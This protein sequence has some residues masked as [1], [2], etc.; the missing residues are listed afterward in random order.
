MDDTL[1]LKLTK[2]TAR[3]FPPKT[4]FISLF[5]ALDTVSEYDDFY[6]DKNHCIYIKGESGNY[7]MIYEGSNGEWA[8]VL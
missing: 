6:F 3:K 7:R 8:T 2:E 5:G 4:Q 1:I